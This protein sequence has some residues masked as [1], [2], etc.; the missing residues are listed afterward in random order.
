MKKNYLSTWQR[1]INFVFLC[2]L[3]LSFTTEAQ[4]QKIKGVVK[5]NTG[6]PLPGVNIK[7]KGTSTGTITNFNGEF[8]LN[9]ITPS[10]TIIFSFMGFEPQEMAVGTQKEFAI[11]LEESLEVLSEI[12]VVGYGTQK[13]ENLTGAVGV[14]TPDKDIGNQAVTNTETLL[15]GRIAGVQLT[16]SGGKPG[17]GAEITIRGNGTL[18]NSSPLVLIDGV[19][20]SMQDIL[21]SDIE[22]V[23]VLKDAASASIYGTRAANGVILVTTK[24]GDDN[25]K[26]KLSYNGY[27]GLQKATVLPDLLDSWDYMNLKNEANTNAGRAPIYTTDEIDMAKAGSNPYYYGNTDW[28]DEVFKDGAFFQN[29]QVSLTQKVGK[30]Q[31]L[32]SVGYL[33]QEGIMYGTSAERLNYR[34]N[35]RS[36]LG[37]G[38]TFGTNFFGAVKN[39][40]ESADTDDQGV[41]RLIAN[42]SPLVPVYNEDGSWGSASGN[43]YEINTKNP[44]YYATEASRKTSK[45]NKNTINP[46]LE[47]NPI[48]G[49]TFKSNFSYSYTSGLIKAQKHD[50]QLTD[51]DGNDSDISRVQNSL[52]DV[53]NEYETVQWE[54]T[55]N[56]AKEFNKHSINLLAGTTMNSYAHRWSKVKVTDLPSNDLGQIGSGSNPTVDGTFN[57]SRL[58]SVFGRIQYNFDDRYLLEGNIRTDGS[59]KFPANNRY[60]IFPAVSAGWI[61]SNEAFLEGAENFLSFGKIRANWGQLGND[62]IGYYPYSQTYT[63]TDGY[64]FDGSSIYNGGLAVTDLANPDIKWE[65]TTSYGIGAD[66]GFWNDKLSITADYFVKDTDDIL[67]KLPIPG[68]TGVS[69]PAYQNAGRVRNTGWELAVNHYNSIGNSGI[70]Y[71]VG[72]NVTTIQNE[73]IEMQGESQYPNNRQINTEGQPIGSFYGYNNTGIYRTKEDLEKY[74]YIDGQTPQLGDLIYEDI[75]GD[76]I[77]NDEDRTIIGNPN[78]EF[79]YGIN[80]GIS[81]KGFDVKLFFQGVQNIDIYSSSTGNHSGSGNNLMNWTTD[82]MDRW[83]PENTDASKPRLGN[84]NNEQISSFWVEDASYF[85]LKNVE[86]GYSFN[87]NVCRK[88][89]LSGLRIY[90]NSTNPLTWSKIDHWDPER[91]ANQSRNEAYPQTTTLTFGTNITF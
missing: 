89:K 52:Q 4:E 90:T 55:V 62:K 88:L 26:V 71:N 40:T 2:L 16:Q 1:F 91:Y 15:Q 44:L 21:P 5:D 84:V 56:Y 85:R 76:G 79:M 22:S 81:Y 18:N 42:S 65:T 80:L 72:F 28:A 86:V 30:T 68:A 38:F 53:T 46:Y 51:N 36:D 14:V 6:Q 35:L 50:F 9:G 61:F 24:K 69:N 41:M 49:L 3:F 10:E 78:P 74:A 43:P 75:N 54:N 7:I 60:A 34:I 17:A 47:F 29:H 31:Y 77:I 27:A 25:E 82:W 59:S 66:F 37:K 83:T 23:S 12:V 58:L 70:K 33:D 11:V 39:S 63:P 20:G 8:S 64:P 19:P 45:S 67:L 48:A 13:K 73:I 57:E 87:E 32:A